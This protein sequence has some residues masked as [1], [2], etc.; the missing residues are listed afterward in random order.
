MGRFSLPKWAFHTVTVHVVFGC[1][2]T[3][4]PVPNQGVHASE[5]KLHQGTFMNATGASGT[6]VRNKLGEQ[7]LHGARHAA[8]PARCEGLRLRAPNGDRTYPSSY[9]RARLCC[10]AVSYFGVCISG[11]ARFVLT[12][13]GII[14]I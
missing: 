12:P 13:A 6:P 2:G 1:S 7:A 9:L 3:L 8:V 5:D 14:F 4:S 11:V 10:I